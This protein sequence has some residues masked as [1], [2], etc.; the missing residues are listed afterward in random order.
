MVNRGVALGGY[1]FNLPALSTIG[2]LEK[3]IINRTLDG[4]QTLQM[5]ISD[6]GWSTMKIPYEQGQKIKWE[7]DATKLTMCSSTIEIPQLG[8]KQKLSKGIN[9]I[10]FHPGIHQELV[11][12]CWMGMMKGKFIAKPIVDPTLS[13]LSK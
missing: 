1:T 13:K 7:I 2:M 6:K 10:E 4:T 5:K 12:T 11:Y 3:P 9:V 8:I